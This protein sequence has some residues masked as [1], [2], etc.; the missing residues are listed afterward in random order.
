MLIFTSPHRLFKDLLSFNF[1]QSCS[2]NVFLSH[3]LF[4]STV[5]V[6]SNEGLC[7]LCVS[8]GKGIM[9]LHLQF[10]FQTSHQFPFLVIC[11]HP[12]NLSR[13][14]SQSEA[15]ASPL[16]VITVTHASLALMQI[17]T[18]SCKCWHILFPLLVYQFLESGICGLHFVFLH[19]RGLYECV[20]YG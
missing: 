7:L 1:Y 19:F 3:V 12:T 13:S 6:T 8:R 20:S 18:F 2:Q 14:S 4:T 16:N 17:F 5:A 9:P 11:Y 10:L 15:T